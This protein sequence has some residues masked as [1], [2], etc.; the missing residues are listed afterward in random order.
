MKKIKKILL[1]DDSRAVNN[2]NESLL[3]R[4][5]RFEEIVKYSDPL[6]AIESLKNDLLKENN[7]P[8]IIFLDINMPVMDGFNFLDIYIQLDEIIKSDYKP[9]IVIVSDY[10]SYENFRKSKKYKSYGL[11]GHITKPL[12]IK[13]VN[14]L[15]IDS[16]NVINT[17]DN[18]P[19]FNSSELT[20]E[21]F[22]KLLPFFFEE[23]IKD[24]EKM[25]LAFSSKEELELKQLAHKISGSALSYSAQLISARAR[26][27]ENSVNL[28]R[29]DELEVEMIRLGQSI[30][31]SHWYAQEEFNII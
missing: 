11:V 27:I 13:G 25:K 2:R 19:I 30:S 26:I 29:V 1:I 23:V 24:F 16:E 28:N 14:N 8:E 7:L 9:I 17:T 12:D 10:I 3:N 6:E 21:S 4:M 18:K 20:E 31:Y 15:L 5:N 22:K